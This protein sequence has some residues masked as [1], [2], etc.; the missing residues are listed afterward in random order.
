VAEKSYLIQRLLPHDKFNDIGCYEVCFCL[1]GRWKGILVDSSLP[2]IARKARSTGEKRI[3][4]NSKTQKQSKRG[5]FQ[6]QEDMVIQPAFAAGNV[7]WPAIIEKAYAKVH[8]SYSRL[9]GGF[10]SEAFYDLTG[11]PVER[12]LFRNIY[13]YDELFARLLSFSNAG[14]LMGVC[15]SAGGDGLVPCH[16]Y[17][18]LGVYEIHDA[19][20]GEQK[21]VTNFFQKGDDD[22]DVIFVEDTKEK[23]PLGSTI[24]LARIRN[25]WGVREWKGKWSAESVEWTS[26]IKSAIGKNAYKQGDG[27]FFM[28][29]EDMVQRF[30]HMD[31]AKCQ[32]VRRLYMNR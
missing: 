4:S 17:S 1:D 23:R 7:S 28:S 31:I 21:K 12:I 27:T 29:Y 20:V 3:A 6:I 24:R 32:K 22:K 15:T 25:P 10:V 13:D 18:L 14:F 26:K 11:A 16:A 19:V 2:A 30:D 8:G 5:S 9:S